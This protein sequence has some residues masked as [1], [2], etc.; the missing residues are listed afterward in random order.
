MIA[1]RTVPKVAICATVVIRSRVARAL[2]GLPIATEKKQTSRRTLLS[3]EGY[4][5]PP[6]SYVAFAS[7]CGDLI[8][9][10]RSRMRFLDSAPRRQVSRRQKAVEPGSQTKF[11]VFFSMIRHWAKNS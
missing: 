10:N 4:R 7:S 8:L 3:N 11:V 9:D 6:S 1:V 5:E 2:N